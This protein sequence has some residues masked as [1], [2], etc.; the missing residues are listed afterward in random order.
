[1]DQGDLAGS[2]VYV[3]PKGQVALPEAR[4]IS[5]CTRA[6]MGAGREPEFP[7]VSQ[8]GGMKCKVRS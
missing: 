4:P 7:N 2:R 8:R 5:R 1:M 6:G 3:S